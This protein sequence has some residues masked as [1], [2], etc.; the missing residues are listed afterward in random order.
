MMSG[1]D[2]S[3][4]RVPVRP[5][6]RT[7]D[8]YKEDQEENGTLLMV[9]MILLDL[10]KCGR[11]ARESRCLG[12]GEGAGGQEEEERGVLRMDP[13]EDSRASPLKQP[14]NRA[15]AAAGGRQEVHEKRHGCPFAGCGKMYG[16]S[17][18]LKAHLRVH[19]GKLGAG[20]CVCV[21]GG[22]HAYTIKKSQV[23]FS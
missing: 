21:R 6:G 11:D 12:G 3:A 4:D 19:T 13:E 8:M 16:K 10:R 23:R 15:R 9:A 5:S 22:G 20:E 7:E 17:S 14:R 1:F 18:H 2:V